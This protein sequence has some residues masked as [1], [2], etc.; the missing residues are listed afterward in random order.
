MTMAE[1]PKPRLPIR[2][3]DVFAEY[4]KLRALREGRPLDEA[5][6]YGLWLA[7]VVASRRYGASSAGTSSAGEARRERD[8]QHAGE[9]EEE[10]RFRSLGDELQTDE[11]FD[12]EIVARMGEDFYREVFAPTIARHFERGDRYE[13]IRDAVRKEWKPS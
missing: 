7:K 4:S 10:D 1:Q 13:S 6:G 12:R 3:F 9:A 2:R 11:R 5:K 8:E